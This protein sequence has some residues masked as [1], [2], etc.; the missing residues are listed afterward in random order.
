VYA[1][2]EGR[3]LIIAHDVAEEESWKMRDYLDM[4]KIN[5]S[6]DSIIITNETC[7]GNDK[8]ITGSGLAISY[9]KDSRLDHIKNWSRGP[10]A[11]VVKSELEEIKDPIADYEILKKLKDDFDNEI[12][13]ILVSKNKSKNEIVQFCKQLLWKYK[14]QN[15]ILFYI[16]NDR[17]ALD[18][19]NNFNYPSEKYFHHFIAQVYRNPYT[20]F[21]EIRWYPDRLF[22]LFEKQPF[23]ERYERIKVND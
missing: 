3:R 18:N 4:L 22:L 6:L 21:D 15:R 1:T 5:S 17:E 7:R 14:H 9:K 12:L 20:E 11:F 13:Y 8:F 19:R 16:Y 2:G 23:K 10:A